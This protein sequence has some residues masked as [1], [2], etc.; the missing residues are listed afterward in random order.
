MAEEKVVRL[1]GALL[2][3]PLDRIRLPERV[4][5]D[6]LDEESLEE[7]GN[8]LESEGLVAPIIVNKIEAADGFYEVHIGHR[9]FT[10]A[11]LRGFTAIPAFVREK[12][13]PLSD[14]IAVISENIHRKDLDPFE[15]ARAFF[16]MIE[17]Y[18]IGVQEL[19]RRIHR[20]ESYVNKR[21]GLLALHPNAQG[22]IARRELSLQHIPVLLK[23]RDPEEQLQ[24]A[25]MA[26]EQGLTGQDLR[27]VIQQRSQENST[28]AVPIKGLTFEKASAHVGTFSRWVERMSA[29]L[30]V[31][32]ATPEQRHALA[33]SIRDCVSLMKRQLHFVEDPLAYQRHVSGTAQ[34]PRNYGVEWPA[35][36]LQAILAPDRPSDAELARILG[37][38]ESAIRD[39]RSRATR[40]LKTRK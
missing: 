2:T 7:L 26:Q 32:H 27:T 30:H 17:D 4:L 11:G 33:R 12:G 38:S 37:R 14:M 1:M 22:M 29:R 23:V 5:R 21:L 28:L 20:S 13:T 36:D 9:R 15:E 39:M 35:G 8:S 34:E 18:G 6:D 3:I 24:Y 31:K 25:L 10:A 40:K 16:E 19:A